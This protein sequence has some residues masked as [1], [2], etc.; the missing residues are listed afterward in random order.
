VENL[1][2]RIMDFEAGELD[3]QD[4]IELFQHLV[5]T[6]MAWSLQ[7]SYGRA[8][9]ALIEAGHIHIPPAPKTVREDLIGTSCKCG[10]PYNP[11]LPGY[12]CA[13]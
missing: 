8:A 11:E 4:T 12:A 5:D 3:E 7:G 2:E 9:I 6:G 10:A 1:V 13:R